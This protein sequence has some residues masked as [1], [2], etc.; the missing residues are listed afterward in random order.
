M[1]YPNLLL[2]ILWR[3]SYH[4]KLLEDK[5]PVKNQHSHIKAILG[6]HWRQNNINNTY[7][8]LF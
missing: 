1:F 2:V 6:L 5:P 8:V 4:D 7:Q 3:I